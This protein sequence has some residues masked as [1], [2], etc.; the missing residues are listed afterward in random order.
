MGQGENGTAENSDDERRTG[1]RGPREQN[2]LGARPW[3]RYLYFGIPFLAAGALLSLYLLR[4]VPNHSD[5]VDFRIDGSEIIALGK[6]GH[7]LWRYDTRLANLA[8]DKAYHSRFQLKKNSSSNHG[9]DLPWVMIKDINKDQKQEVLLCTRTTDD[10]GGGTLLCLGNRGKELWRFQAGREM[11]CGSR[12][13][14]SEYNTAGFDIMDIDD[15]GKM[16]TVVISYQPPNW[17]MQLALLDSDGR[18]RGEFWNSGHLTD[19]LLTDLNGNG[20]KEL[21]VAGLNNEYEK[22]CLIV[23]DPENVAGGSPQLKQEFICRGLRPGTEKFYLLFPRTD[24]DLAT[25]PVEA[26]SRMQV[27][28]PNILSLE[29]NISH[30]IFI[31]SSDF[32]LEDVT[33]SHGFMLLHNEALLAGRV[34]SDLNNP[35]YKEALIKGV[36]Y[37]DGKDW[38]TNPTPV[39]RGSQ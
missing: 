14:S 26:I 28:L 5:P 13:Y 12:P 29:A 38:T 17:L 32:V 20:Q 30:L 21:L 27:Q 6:N 19:F 22:G 39:I 23:F 33:F 1:D 24:A 10:H 36:L 31:V 18:A 7:P 8:D 9:V 3:R 35:R 15:D 34:R 2:L 25:Y 37:Y 4:Q 11:W 16:E